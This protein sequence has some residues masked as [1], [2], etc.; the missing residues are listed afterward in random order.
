MLQS[1]D[2]YWSE[3]LKSSGEQVNAEH[4]EWSEFLE[5]V[6]GGDGMDEE[7]SGL[8]EWDIRDYAWNK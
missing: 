1:A 8:F 7:V 2:K 5:W 4:K 6:F 3:V